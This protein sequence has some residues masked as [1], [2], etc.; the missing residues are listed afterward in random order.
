MQEPSTVTITASS[1]AETWYSPGPTFTA[2]RPASG[3]PDSSSR[4]C[5]A[6]PAV[7]AAGTARDGLI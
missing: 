6:A 5:S 1:S 2:R 3:S 4:D 7:A